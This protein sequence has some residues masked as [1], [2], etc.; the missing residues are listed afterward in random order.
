MSRSPNFNQNTER[1]P[2]SLVVGSNF[3]FGPPLN[4]DD[5]D[6]P[7]GPTW[8]PLRIRMRVSHFRLRFNFQILS[9]THGFLR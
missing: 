8:T 3:V 9:K 1:V 2:A 6:D 4:Q 5:Q 7:P